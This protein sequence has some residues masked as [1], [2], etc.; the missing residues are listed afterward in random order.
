MVYRGLYC[1]VVWGLSWA[2]IYIYKYL[3]I[4]IKQPVSWNVNKFFFF[5]GSDFFVANSWILYYQIMFQRMHGTGTSPFKNGIWI[6]ICL[7]V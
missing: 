1:P 3:S 5:R 6:T 2:V 7:D 4:P